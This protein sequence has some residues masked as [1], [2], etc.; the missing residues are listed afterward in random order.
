YAR[1]R[2]RDLRYGLCRLS[3]SS[4]LRCDCSLTQCASNNSIGSLPLTD[5]DWLVRVGLDKARNSNKI[6]ARRSGDSGD[7]LIY[8]RDAA[9]LK[10]CLLLRSFLLTKAGIR[11]IRER[12]TI[13]HCTKM[14]RESKNGQPKT[15]PAGEVARRPGRTTAGANCLQEFG[16]QRWVVSNPAGIGRLRD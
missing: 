8:V 2:E 4:S 14:R 6:S 12:Q 10:L 1:T 7:M 11:I 5:S 3:S 15:S 13:P 16:S 9:D